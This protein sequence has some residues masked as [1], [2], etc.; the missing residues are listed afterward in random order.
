[1]RVIIGRWPLL[2]HCLRSILLLLKFEARHMQLDSRPGSAL[3]KLFQQT[4]LSKLTKAGKNEHQAMLWTRALCRGER[5]ARL[6]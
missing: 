6:C 1:M 4:R 2:Y 5:V 3:Y